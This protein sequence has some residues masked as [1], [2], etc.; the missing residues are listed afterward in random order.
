MAH[1]VTHLFSQA[2]LD[3]IQ[4]AVRRAEQQTSGEI[5]PYVVDASDEY[6][7]AEW[8]LGCLVAVVVLIAAS[9]FHHFS[10][11]WLPLDLAVL[12]VATGFSLLAGVLLVK[13]VPPLKRMFAGKNLI[14]RRVSARAAQAFLSEEVFKTRDRT[15]ILIFVSALEHKVLVVGDAGINAKVDQSEW[16]EVVDTLT[17]AIAKGEPTAGF[18]DAIGKAGILLRREGVERRSD[19]ADELSDNLRIRDR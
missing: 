8:R 10:D 12:M 18:I 13:Y 5:V 4:E 14:E 1:K 9:A 6:E 15:G 16:Q 17:S 2:D 3:N 11:V 7:E 19:D